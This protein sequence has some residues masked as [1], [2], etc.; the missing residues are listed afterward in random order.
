MFKR[1]TVLSLLLV[2]G[3]CIS[4]AGS[5][6]LV[7]AEEDHLGSGAGDT[8]N[9]TVDGVPLDESHFPDAAFRT[10]VKDKFDTTPDNV[11]SQ[12]EISAAKYMTNMSNMG[13]TNLQG[14]EYFTNLISLSCTKN[15]LS[16]L[17]LSQNT[18]LERLDLSSDQL[19]SL[20]VSKCTNLQSLNVQFNSLTSLDVTKCTRLTTLYIHNNAIDSVDISKC[21]NLESF[22]CSNNQLKDLDVSKNV[23]MRNLDCAFNEIRSLDLSNLPALTDLDCR[24]N[25]LTSLNL[26]MNPNI[27]FVVCEKNELRAIK[28]RRHEKL[29][30]LTCY[31][32][33]IT[34]PLE[35]YGCPKLI[36]LMNSVDPFYPDGSNPESANT[37]RYY[38]YQNSNLVGEFFY[39]LST[40][41][42]FD[43]T[44]GDPM[45]S[46]YD[47]VL[48]DGDYIIASAASTNK[49]MLYF[50]DIYGRACPADNNSNVSIW[51]GEEPGECDI[52]TI[53][54]ENGFYTIRQ[55]G[56]QMYLEVGGTNSEGEYFYRGTNV[57]VA[58]KDLLTQKWAISK[59]SPNDQGY[60]IQAQCS[61][62]SVDLQDGDLTNLSNIRMWENNNAVAETW[63]FIPYQPKQPVANGRYMLLSSL[64]SGWEMDVYGN[65]GDIADKTN[66]QLYEDSAQNQYNSFD[67]TK[68]DNGYYK[69]LHAASGKA[70]TVEGG[71]SSFC[72]NISVSTY[73]GSLSQQWAV[74]KNGSGYV[75]VARCSGLVAD[76]Q[77]GVAQNGANV[78][79]YPFSG[80]PNQ[81]WTFAKAE[82]KV[83]FN[84]NGGSGAPSAQT[85]YYK[86]DLYISSSKPTRSKC[87][88]IGWGTSADAT[89]ASYQAGSKYTAD[90]DITLYALWVPDLP[91]QTTGAKAAS[92]S[93]TSIKV[94]WNAVSGAT[95]YEV[96]RAT[97]ANGTFTKLGWVS[98]TSRTCGSLTC[99]KTYYFK[100]RAFVQAGGIKSYGSYSS[101]VSAVPQLAAPGSAK[102]TAAS[103]TSIKVSWNAVSGADGYAVYR[104]TSANGTYSKLGTVTTT[105]RT[106]GSLSSGKQYFFKVCAYKVVNGK[107]CY[108]KYSSVVSAVTTPGTPTVKVASS[109]SSSV[110]LSWGAVSNA[111]GYEVYRSTSANGTYSK[112]GWVSSTSR[113]CTGLTKGK[114]YYFK[115]RAFVEI[116][117][118]KYYGN[119]SS[120]VSK[121]VS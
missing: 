100:V 8:N 81:T 22:S 51:S 75:L 105:N 94:S 61:G 14:I 113:N 71:T 7:K 86:N 68:L 28:L 9:V 50:M 87:S 56:T 101:V 106:C 36:D 89:T 19:T 117:G 45:T 74:I 31:A 70:L 104:A 17:D 88:F 48:P 111:T 18:K 98:A 37:A 64:A 60:R 66:V 1:M 10:Y 76:V 120:V 84:A 29:K 23:K 16:S 79:Q 80:D 26:R 102:A 110:K 2:A 33:P 103:T 119:Y 3:A 34:E 49:N 54:Y 39:S 11:L 72:Q 32:N 59:N 114:T 5:S 43:C 107:T 62:L 35:L 121:S 116:D 46:G 4:L 55:K 38:L 24:S 47:R 85:K 99:G 52:W 65:S 69:I 115:V 91:A 82:Y 21:T 58:S 13:I 92:V 25:K 118:V 73:D 90:K 15:N 63:L 57:Q 93:A 112:L 96:Y 20:N 67:L 44:F 6:Q 27:T 30:K 108:G 40:E 97:S 12:T 95:G 53:T 109:T 77:G 42:N 78:A 41:L 83:T